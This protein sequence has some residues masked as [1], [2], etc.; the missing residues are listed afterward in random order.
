MTLTHLISKNIKGLRYKYITFLL[1]SILSVTIFY[2][3]ASFVMHPNVAYG[4]Q[5][6]AERV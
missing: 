6:H 1:S 4:Y 3:F 5:L 2:L